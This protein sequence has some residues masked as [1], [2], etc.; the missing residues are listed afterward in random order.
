LNRKTFLKQCATA[1]AGLACADL[2]L[3]GCA[4]FPYATF[5]RE[6]DSVLVNRIEI[7]EIGF[8]LVDVPDLP[9]PIYLDQVDDDTF[10]A[11]MLRCTHKGCEVK[12][13]GPILECPCHGSQYT[14]VG[15]VI[16]G[17]APKDLTRYAVETEGEMIRILIRG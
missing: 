10:T 1:T 7:G 13:A 17:P 5:I 4:S 8:V 12:P 15:E 16:E 2:M 6:A 9:A 11:V 14:K 3:T